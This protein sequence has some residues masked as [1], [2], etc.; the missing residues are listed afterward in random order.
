[1]NRWLFY[2]RKLTRQLWVRATAYA[3][4]GIGAALIAAWGAPFVPSEMAERIGNESVEEILTILAS[5]LL[6]V[7]TFSVGAMV[8]AYTS[9][10]SSATPRVAALVTADDRT[11]K[12]LSTFVGA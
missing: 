10:A 2:W 11:Q 1:M 7:A 9:V 4:F 5:S 8:T 6:A 12:A 3:G